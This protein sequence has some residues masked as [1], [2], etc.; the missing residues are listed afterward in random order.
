MPN[1]ELNFNDNDY[2]IVAG[3]VQGNFGTEAGD[4]V[5][6]TVYDEDNQ[7]V[8]DRDGNPSIFYAVTGSDPTNIQLPGFATSDELNLNINNDTSDYKTKRNII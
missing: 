7:I 4:Y 1:L 6:L 5:R 3:K 2:E 8:P